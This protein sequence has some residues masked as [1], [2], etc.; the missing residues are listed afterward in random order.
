MRLLFFGDAAATGFGTVTRDTGIQFVKMGV[1]VRFVSQNALPNLEEP[2]LSRTLSVTSL[3]LTEK[4]AE[5]GRADV[6][7]N[8]EKLFSGTTDEHLA[9]GEPWGDWKPDACLLLGDFY[10]LRMMV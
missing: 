6:R 9:N 7:A 10:G 4:G 5:K 1:D 2:F 3:T 8:L